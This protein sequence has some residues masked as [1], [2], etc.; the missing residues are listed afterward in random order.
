MCSGDGAP[1]GG[2]VC[3]QALVAIEALVGDQELW[4]DELS[5]EDNELAVPAEQNRTEQNLHLLFGGVLN[6]LFCSG[7]CSVRYLHPPGPELSRW[8]C[9][10]AHHADLYA[11]ISAPPRRGMCSSGSAWFLDM[12]ACIHK[13]M[14][15]CIHTE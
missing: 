3:A 10:E 9:G 1:C 5:V 7:T 14:Y 15:T 8:K 2:S 12:H 13:H 6:L 11:T 4:Q